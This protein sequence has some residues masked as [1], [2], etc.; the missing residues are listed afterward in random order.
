[1]SLEQNLQ[2]I[3]GYDFRG[4]ANLQTALS[5]VDSLHKETN[6]KPDDFFFW[7]DKDGLVDPATGEYVHDIIKPESHKNPYIGHI[8]HNIILQLDQWSKN[9]SG[10]AVW[11]SPDFPG[12][13]PGHKIEILKIDKSP[14]G[15]KMTLNEA[16][17][18]DC[19]A[20]KCLEIVKKIF[21]DETGL[22]ENP[23]L[24]RA[25]IITKPGDFD[26][27]SLKQKILL[28]VPRSENY[29]EM[30]DETRNYL[31]NLIVSGY[32]SHLIAYEMQRLNALGEFSISCPSSKSENSL[33][34]S[35]LILSNSF[36]T[37]LG[38]WHDGTCRVCHA[39]TWV[40]PCNICKPCEAKF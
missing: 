28:Y 2:T 12:E 36:I 39:S 21:P 6:R 27:D 5:H 19:P 35:E 23:D 18:F 37:E 24:L 8:E 25:K 22:F 13:Y 32:D 31:G 16:I 30:T 1:M 11:I 33:P 38:G 7:I 34:L 10:V 3:S 20:Q 9:D 26:L 40:G 17:L 14:A 15:Q 4:I 29:R